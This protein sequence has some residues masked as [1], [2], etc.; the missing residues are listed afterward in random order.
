MTLP[1][2]AVDKGSKSFKDKKE[3]QEFK[4]QV[5]KRA[6]QIKETVFVE[7]VFL[8]DAVEQWKDFCLGYTEPTRYLYILLVEKFIEFLD[9]EVVYISDLETSDIN[10]FLNSLMKR[11]I[12]NSSVNNSLTSIKSLCSYMSEN[13]KI[14][15]PAQ[16]IKK[17][18]EGDIDANYWSMEEYQR[19]LMKS[20]DFARRCRTEIRL[21]RGAQYG[22]C[23]VPF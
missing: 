9:G 10:T 20:P 4:V 5:E 8:D 16:G 1:D 18:K 17:L 12:A 3:A 19:V 6:K 22:Y 2:G 7:A 23:P 21:E 11:G 13:Y 14:A 15:N